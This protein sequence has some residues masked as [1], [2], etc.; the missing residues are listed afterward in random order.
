MIR[1]ILA[2]V[3]IC[4]S[5]CISTQLQNSTLSQARTLTDLQYRMILDNV[6]MFRAAP[7]SMPWHIKIAQGSITVNDNVNPGLRFAWPPTSREIGLSVARE[8]Q[9]SWTVTPVIDPGE[10]AELKVLYEAAAQ[11]SWIESGEMSDAVA[12]G[13][14]GLTHVSVR[15]P[16]LS[17]LTDL[18]LKVLEKTKIKSEDRSPLQGPLPLISK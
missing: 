15:L 9:T 12:F 8:W 5:G 18:T 17:Q 1:I 10:L 6:A 16:H 3:A 11:Q 4:A 13:Q 7:G 2:M 14:Y